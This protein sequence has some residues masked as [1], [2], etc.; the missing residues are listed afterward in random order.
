[1]TQQDIIIRLQLIGQQ[2][3]ILANTFA[4]NLKWGRKNIIKEYKLLIILSSY[5]TL[6]EDYTVNGVN[7][8]TPLQLET[9]FSN[10]SKLTK[11]CFLPYGYTYSQNNIRRQFD[12]SFDLSFF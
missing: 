1:M 2:Y 3:S 7:C 4:N 12:D 6:L 11:I 5:I 10:T 9:L 8:I